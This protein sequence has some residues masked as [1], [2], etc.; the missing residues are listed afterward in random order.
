V[1]GIVG[2]ASLEMLELWV[3][4][5]CLAA[6]LLASLY[7]TFFRLLLKFSPLISQARFTGKLVVVAMNS[8][9]LFASLTS[10]I[11]LLPYSRAFYNI[12]PTLYLSTLFTATF[13]AV[14][15]GINLLYLL[16]SKHIDKLFE[17]L[18]NG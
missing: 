2:G 7:F 13:T 6:T 3:S 8:I 17:K 10:H 5:V 12:D 15:S 18:W 16:Y 14:F 4:L 9:I 11:Y 1:S